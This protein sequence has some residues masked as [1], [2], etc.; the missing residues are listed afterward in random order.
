MW[1]T[2]ELSHR[3][4]VPLQASHLMSTR[5]AES[6]I[7]PSET[8]RSYMMHNFVYEFDQQASARCLPK[9]AQ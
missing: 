9:Q 5:A 8:Q 1:C 7:W 4:R 2:G 6:S 3:S